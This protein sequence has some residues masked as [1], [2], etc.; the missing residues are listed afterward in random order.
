MKTNQ[1]QHVK[2]I[3]YQ[4]KPQP[5]QPANIIKVKDYT[6]KPLLARAQ[7]ISEAS[8]SL[9]TTAMDLACLVTSCS[10]LKSSIWFV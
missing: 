8:I 7:E 4:S 2:N 3:E 10:L 6:T 1:K 5:T 9:P